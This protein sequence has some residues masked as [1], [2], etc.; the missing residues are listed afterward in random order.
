[1]I[2][3]DNKTAQYYKVVARPQLTG[4]DWIPF[5]WPAGSTGSTVV[6]AWHGLDGGV[7]HAARSCRGLAGLDGLDGGVAHGLDGGVAHGG[8]AHGATGSPSSGAAGA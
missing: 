2:L 3:W 1:M 5:T 8:V 4:E 6:W 7:A